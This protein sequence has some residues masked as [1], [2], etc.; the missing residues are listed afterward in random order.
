MMD[1][2]LQLCS[3]VLYTRVCVGSVPK[4]PVL[5]AI[6]AEAIRATIS[7]SFVSVMALPADLSFLCCALIT[8][9]SFYVEI[10]PLGIRCTAARRSRDEIVGHGHA[11]LAYNW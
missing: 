9:S 2:F 8:S 1:T 5:S 6:V 4:P 11:R 10:E 7:V 3:A